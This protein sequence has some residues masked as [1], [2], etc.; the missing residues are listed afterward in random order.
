LRAPQ[1]QEFVMPP[2]PAARPR[3]ARARSA[4][5]QYTTRTFSGASQSRNRASNGSSRFTLHAS[6]SSS[7]PPTPWLL[8]STTIGQVPF[9]NGA[10]SSA[11][12]EASAPPLH[13]RRRLFA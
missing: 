12:R 4:D 8:Y 11:S 5:D 9:L 10:I 2:Q 3:A 7:S 1:Q 13:A 6:G